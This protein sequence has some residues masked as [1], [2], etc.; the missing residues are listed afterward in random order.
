MIR[1]TKEYNFEYNRM[2]LFSDVK[3]KLMLSWGQVQILYCVFYA[4]FKFF[5][6]IQNSKQRPKTIW[7]LQIL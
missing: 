2:N 6:W 7:S 5:I 4:E 3:V 1:L